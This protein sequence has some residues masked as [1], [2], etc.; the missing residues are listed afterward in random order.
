MSHMYISMDKNRNKE[1]LTLSKN[2]AIIFTKRNN[3]FKTNTTYNFSISVEELVH[4]INDSTTKK[5]I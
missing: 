1:D 4:H 3:N 5:H 2:D